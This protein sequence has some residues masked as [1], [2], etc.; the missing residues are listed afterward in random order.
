MTLINL[1]NHP[2][3]QW[4]EKQ[5]QAALLFGPI[6]DIPFPLVSPYATDDEIDTLVDEYLKKILAAG[7]STV[8]LQGEFTFTFRLLLKLRERNIPAV[9]AVSDRKSV[10]VTLPNGT[11]ERRSIFEFV[12]FRPY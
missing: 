3:A 7:E 8:M 10:E 9:A 5:R 11:T 12:R 2:S 6:L 1:S 4:G